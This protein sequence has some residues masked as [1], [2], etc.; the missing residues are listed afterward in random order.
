MH[1]YNQSKRNESAE[2]RRSDY[3]LKLQQKQ[4]N[5][6]LKE[7]RDTEQIMN[8]WFQLEWDCEVGIFNRHTMIWLCFFAVVSRERA[9]VRHCAQTLY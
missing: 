7:I 6:N 3:R 9:R 4:K 2:T 1:T 8:A 5:T